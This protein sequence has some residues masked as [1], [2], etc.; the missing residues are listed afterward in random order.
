MDS[1]PRLLSSL[2][3]L[4][5]SELCLFSDARIVASDGGVVSSHC[6]LLAAASTMMENAIGDAFDTDVLIIC[7]DLGTSEVEAFVGSILNS[8]ETSSQALE[9]A[10]ATFCVDLQMN[11]VADREEECVELH[12]SNAIDEDDPVLDHPARPPTQEKGFRPAAPAAVK[13]SYPCRDCDAVLSTSYSLKVHESI[14]EGRRDN[15]CGVCSRRFTQRSHLTVHERTHTGEKGF[16]CATCG[17]TFAVPSNLR[18]H[19][20][21]HEREDQDGGG[22]E[23]TQDE[24]IENDDPT[25]TEVQPFLRESDELE[26]EHII[27]P[28]PNTRQQ[29]VCEFCAKTYTKL[30]DLTLHVKTHTHPERPFSCADCDG[31][32]SFPN[33]SALKLHQKLVHDKSSSS[34]SITTYDCTYCARI[35]PSR[36]ALDKHVLVHTGTKPHACPTCG[37][38][39]T[40][41]SHVNHHVR[42][43]HERVER[44][45]NHFC[46][47]C[48]KAFT[49]SSMLAKHAKTH[50]SERPFKCHLCT[51]GFIQKTHLQTHVLKHKYAVTVGQKEQKMCLTLLFLSVA[52]APFSAASAASRT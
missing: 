12:E 17:K 15:E 37:K 26:E 25:V 2:R 40:Q 39:F 4:T 27:S 22:G 38:R 45:K 16:M 21:S 46:A 20:L 24:A 32:P 44:P 42:T 13:R 29:H 6:L 1:V 49:N 48:G 10:F 9:D 3:D 19:Q 41:I 33:R 30:S 11:K 28:H 23:R 14:H 47:L 35:C 7:P 50:T 31:E 52:S 18:K 36:S 8:V 5:P 43:V 34:S 51:K